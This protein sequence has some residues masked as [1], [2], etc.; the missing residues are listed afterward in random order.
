MAAF[1]VLANTTPALAQSAP[2]M[3]LPGQA[4]VDASGGFDYV[5]PIAVPPGTAGIA[6]NLSLSYS[7]KGGDGFEG[8][9]W[10]LNGLP[11]IT[12]CPETMAQNGVHG[13]VNYNKQDRF[14]L[15]GQQLVVVNGGNYGVDG[16]E[17]RTEV[18]TYTKIISN[19]NVLTG[20]GW[21]SAWTKS[22]QILQFGH[23]VDSKIYPINADGSGPMT[24]ARAWA[25]N[26]IADHAG[27][28]MS[29]TYVNDATNGQ[30]YPTRIDYT[31]NDGA[32][33]AAYA[34][35]RLSYNT[36]SNCTRADITPM[37][38]AGAVIQTT[39]LLCDIKTFIG[40]A[41]VSDYQLG[42]SLAHA[43]TAQNDEL[44]TV[45]RCDASGT[46]LAPTTF[47]W[48]GSRD[49]PAV[50]GTPVSVTQL[51]GILTSG[52]FNGDGL[53]DVVA[54]S[55]TCP[56]HGQ[57][58]RSQQD[59]TFVSADMTAK[60]SYY[61]FH[62]EMKYTYNAQAC[63]QNVNSIA[64]EIG[65][66]G[67]ADLAINIGQWI[68]ESEHNLWIEAQT[69]EHLQNNKSGALNQVGDA[70][71]YPFFV[72]TSFASQPYGGALIT[73]APG[74]FNGDGRSDGFLGGAVGRPLFSNGDG[75]YTQGDSHSGLDST[76]LIAGDFNG[77]GCID[78][79]AP[80]LGNLDFFCQ[81]AIAQATTPNW[82]GD[83]LITGD[84]NGDGNADILVVKPSGTNQLW[85]GTGTGFI[86]SS[87]AVP[88]SWR[89]FA[90]YA[91]DYNGD[92]KTDLA[93][94]ANTAGTTG[95]IKLSTGMG[96]AELG[97]GASPCI[98]SGSPAVSVADW[99]SD[100]ADDL[101]TPVLGYQ[102]LF[103]YVPELIAAV[104]NGIGAQTTV[105]YKRLNNNGT[106]YAKGTGAAYPTQ[107]IDEPIYAV[108][109]IEASDGIGGT[110]V[111]NY[112][113]AGAKNDLSGRGFLGFASVT[114]TD[115][116]TGI[117]TT[118]NYRQDFPYIGLVDSQTSVHGAVTLSSLA[119]VYA[120]KPTCATGLPA[121]APYPL[122]L[123]SATVH[124]HDLDGSVMPTTETDS[125]DFTAYGDPK[126]VVQTVSGAGGGT[127]TRTSTYEFSQNDPDNWIIGHVN[128]AKVIAQYGTSDPVT[129]IDTY[130]Y[131]TTTGFLTEHVV[132]PTTGP[133][134]VVADY[135]RDPHT[136]VVTKV[137]ISGNNF[138]TRE[139][140]ATYDGGDRFPITVTNALSQTDHFSYDFGLGVPT[141]HKDANNLQTVWTYDTFG[142]LTQETRPDGTQTHVAY[143]YCSPYNG[144]TLSCFGNQSFQAATSVVG[145]DGTTQIAP[146]VNIFY[147]ALGR[148]RMQNT[149]GFDGTLVRTLVAYNGKY[150]L[151]Q[152]SRPYSVATQSPAYTTYL[153]DDLGRTTK[154]T[155]PDASQTTYAYDAL[156]SSV[157]NDKGQTTATLSNGLGLPQTVTDALAGVTHYSYDGFGD[158]L[159]AT[160]PA[161][162]TISNTYD[163]RGR[164][165]QSND[166][167]MGDWT[168]A[169]DAL[170]ELTSQIDAKSQTTTLQ[171]DLLGRVTNRAE[172]D[173]AS[174]WTYDTA[175]HGIGMLAQAACAAGAS[176]NACASGGATQTFHYDALS[177]Q[178]SL[179]L[180]IG[181]ESYSTQDTY[182]TISGKLSNAV[183]FSGFS[184]DYVYNA[185]GYLQ[186]LQDHTTTKPYW[187]AN[188]M[189]AENH[190]T[191]AYLGYSDPTHQ[192]TQIFR[193]YDPDTGNPTSFCATATAA[194]CDGAVANFGYQWDTIGNLTQRT[195][196][197]ESLTEAFTYD[198]LNRLTRAQPNSANQVVRYDAAGNITR[199]GG[200]CGT[201]SCMTYGAGTAGPHALTAVTGTV[202]GVVNPTYAYDPNG[203]ML[204]GAGRT[205]AYTSFNMTGSVTDVAPIGTAQAALAYDAGHNR[206]QQCVPDCTAPTTVTEYLNDGGSNV[207]SERVVSG[208]NVTWQDY[209]IV[210]GQGLF[211]VRK[212]ALGVTPEV[213]VN[214]IV[215]DPLQSVSILTDDAGHIA[216]RLSYD[217]W[218]AR[219]NPDGTAASPAC[220]L[221]S[222][223]TRG[224]TSQEM[225]DSLCLINMNARIYD[226]TI[227]R[228]MSAD[229][230]IPNPMN[231]QSFNRY[232]YVNNN[233]MNLIDPTGMIP[234]W[235]CFGPGV[236]GVSFDGNTISA[237][238]AQLAFSGG[239][240]PAELDS[241]GLGN[242]MLNFGSYTFNVGG[243]PKD[244]GPGQFAAGI[245]WA[246][247]QMPNA[248][249]VVFQFP[250]FGQLTNYAVN[251]GSSPSDSAAGSDAGSGIEE[252]VVSCHCISVWTA[253]STNGG[254][255]SAGL[256][257][258]G[259]N[260]NTANMIC[261]AAWH[262]SAGLVG[263]VYSQVNNGVPGN[264]SNA[265]I[266][267]GNQYTV[268]QNGVP[269]G[270]VHSYVGQNGLTVAN[271][272]DP[273]HIL[274]DGYANRNALQVNGAWYSVT[275]GSGI[276]YYGGAFI[277]EANQVLG[278][279]IFNNMD[280]SIAS[281]LYA[282]THH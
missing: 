190:L 104:D 215:S 206:I 205:V 164:K 50:T 18:D 106:F 227:G 235:S 257:T 273:G 277:A 281:Q 117:A 8:L 9:G 238:G 90:I 13:G 259:H 167:D 12:R 148:F 44:A 219:R 95:H 121:A 218:G 229:T 141:S 240:T 125:S 26:R 247:K 91:G 92:G 11:A 183:A 236:W 184:T 68:Y 162:H 129:R 34:S 124:R 180:G 220:S 49:A 6:P 274:F 45:A 155:M 221:T 131:D 210:P 122:F 138:A 109:H 42:Y 46:C 250:Q 237:A 264:P 53:I 133:M 189:D 61:K 203:N 25:V 216:E 176:G 80:T 144:G 103:S 246:E 154:A 140:D 52:D 77:D 255:Q 263:S 173:M 113:Y 243:V 85:F 249:S 248:S 149:N 76:T 187:R 47:T 72:M 231:G 94:F 188:S 14:C 158:L 185:T 56:T 213:T 269:V 114:M 110:Y 33:I 204:T 168:Y 171:Y 252:V 161:G 193:N 279:G 132:E 202:N 200:V 209:L 157:T 57:I 98:G 196:A 242:S 55:T 73:E 69:T 253:S 226:P 239:V 21:F 118:T 160:D 153:Y 261:A 159:T 107:D 156:T 10:S 134:K 41:V 244:F 137:N 265:A 88:D 197:V 258:G 67:Y 127:E 35:V 165:T 83:T 191:R 147:D 70:Q 177:R 143:N 123:C 111:S 280:T 282:A 112:A 119:N 30:Y 241:Y 71:G 115:P 79:L 108:S 174:T 178:A 5:A 201:D 120:A 65:G 15:G 24:V 28:Y 20:N 82:T 32:G 256:L 146:P 101:W 51:D 230:V 245:E 251:L 145:S 199:K 254:S 102:Y 38:Q 84:F 268:Y 78:I 234:C 59:G 43:D 179:T 228:F 99:N 276:S 130:T 266:V 194:P 181:T 116:Q 54:Y 17:Y 105:V 40:G 207:V 275:H 126:T 62:D 163:V 172:P 1:V 36:R 39:K 60:Y 87:F 211:G 23:S 81:P 223:T 182:D 58:Y 48:H 16:T 22:G 75:T 93:F 232:S 3:A 142:R 175:T 222:S 86:L 278:P 270:T 150:Q 63:F 128:H 4:N 27:N 214:Y 19:G 66:D 64:E 37:Y 135:T 139:T 166:P 96:F 31:A 272:T 89:N 170:S 186:A 29:V 169:Y 2:M 271:V 208:A 7:S 152:A 195:D 233:P 198:P 262:C 100:G 74:D 260:Y 136:G 224:Y 267:S 212:D 225:M 217:A 151:A 97:C 192:W